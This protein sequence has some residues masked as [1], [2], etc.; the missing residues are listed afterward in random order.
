MGAFLRDATGQAFNTRDAI[1]RIARASSVPVYVI[2]D[3]AVGIGSVG[4]DVVDYE[5]HGR[6]GARLALRVLSGERPD[7]TDAGTTRPIVDW[8]E[9]QRWGLDER[10]LPPDSVVLFREPS[11]WERHRGLIVG[12]AALLLLQ[13]ALIAALLVHRALRRR[14]RRALAERLRFETL[15]SDLSAMFAAGPATEVDQQIDTG[16]RRIVEDLGADRAT[17]GALSTVVGRRPGDPLLDTG[18]RDAAPAEP[19]RGVA[20]PWIVSQLRRGQVVA[21]RT[22]RRISRPRRRRTGSA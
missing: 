6:T 15:L 11:V 22:P 1:A 7:P 3:H 10:R 21:A 18:R 17:L 20:V 9:I 13:S 2:Q 16:L 12:A 5:A 14:V 19:I 8:R 4:G